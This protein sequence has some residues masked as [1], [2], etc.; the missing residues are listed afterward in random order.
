[1]GYGTFTETDW[2]SYRSTTRVDRA[3]SAHDIY[4]SGARSVKSD[5]L[6]Y[7]VVRECRDSDEHPN[8]TPIIIGLDVTGSMS[9]I[10]TNTA[11]NV[12][13]TIIQIIERKCV[14]DPQILFSAIDDYITSD[15]RCLQVTQFESDIRVAKQ[16]YE[17][18]F[19]ERGGGNNWES[20]A[21]LWYF[22]Q[23]HTDC[24]AIKKGRKGIII[25]LGDDGLQPMISQ[26]EIKEVFGDSVPEDVSTKDLLSQL[27]RNWE[28]FHI[29]LERD[30][31]SSSGVKK[32][33]ND[34]LGTH[35]IVLDDVDKIS[36]VIIGLL[37]TVKGDSL[38]VIT[39]D[40]DNSTAL[41]VRNALGALQVNKSGASD[42]V[43]F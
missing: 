4:R 38:D 31:W 28:I 25:T 35:H 43:V 39:K 14:P 40:W 18:S 33:W 6:P 22:A 42:V 1:M 19:I 37:Q 15:E 24:D 10:L 36:E 16:M 13:E 11:K 17:L 41:A 8:A 27:N 3:S 20:Y 29:T 7:G 32:S 12:G 26:T 23:H 34:A 21:D 9:D 30:G 2:S 5:F